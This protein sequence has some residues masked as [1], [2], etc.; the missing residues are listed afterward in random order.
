MQSAG[1]ILGVD[2]EKEFATPLKKFCQ[3]IILR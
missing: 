2:D 3:K 1:K